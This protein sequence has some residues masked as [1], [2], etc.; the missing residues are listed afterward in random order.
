MWDGV[1]YV[2]PSH[3]PIISEGK[4]AARVVVTHA[5]PSTVMLLGWPEISPKSSSTPDINVQ[6]RPGNTIS[7][8]ACLLRAKLYQ[9][10]T[11]GA[12]GQ[13]AA[14]GWRMVS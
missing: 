4:N 10:P 13:F 1:T 14:L 3:N 11:N 9:G 2:D 7:V 5:G 8:S 6:L 12:V